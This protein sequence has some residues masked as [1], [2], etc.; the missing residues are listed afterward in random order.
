MNTRTDTNIPRRTFLKTAGASAGALWLQPGALL[1][2]PARKPGDKLRVAFIGMGAQIQGHVGGILQLGHQVAALCD[3]DAGQLQK[4]RKTHGDGVAKAVD[5]RDYR[6]LLEKEKDID[7]VVI[8]TPDHWHAR[9]CQAAMA[10]GKHVYC[11]KPLTHT[12]AEAR[13]LRILTKTTKV[14]TQTGNQ[15]SASGN[16]RRSMELIASGLFGAITEIHI[17]HP[18]HDWPSGVD[19]PAGA[20]PVPTSLDWKTWLGPAPERSYKNDIYHPINWRGWYDFGGGS[21]ADFCCHAFNLPVRA[22]ELDYPN[23]IEISG[24]EMGK[25]S[26]PKSCTVHY[27]FPARGSRAPVKMHFYTGGDVPPEAATAAHRASFGG[28]QRTGCILIGEKGQLQSGLWNSD[29]YV[30][31]N[32]DTRFVGADNHPL[33]KKVPKSIP[34]VQGHLNEWVDA[35]LGGPKVFSDFEFGG[36][37]T[38][39]GLA[40][41][42]A[43]R[44]QKNIDWDGPAMK[45][46]GMPEADR[47]IRPPQHA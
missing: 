43:L 34:R 29:C 36:R 20:D 11:E 31:L 45:V 32:G 16:L 3:V 26:F 12:I 6:V 17:W 25:E 44:L 14:I 33:A 37:L 21:I 40:G 13:Q 10:A 15:G 24:S 38:E 35:C 30:M 42:I 18:P 8:A 2:A 1:A 27:H 46:P 22:L 7:A 39:I 4:T 28:L 23:R 47:F 9:I 5:Y 41:I 19:R